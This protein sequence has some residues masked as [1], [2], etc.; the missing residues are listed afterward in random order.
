MNEEIWK[1]IPDFPDYAVSSEGRVASLRFSRLVRSRPGTDGAR[2]VALYENRCRRDV[3]IHQVVAMAFVIGHEW[4]DPVGH[5]NGNRADNR[6]ENLH[7]Y[8]YN[9]GFDLE[10]DLEYDG[11]DWHRIC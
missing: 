4:G 10:G 7:F 1:Y 5:I 2:K 8:V 3:Y 9:F 11:V 6:L